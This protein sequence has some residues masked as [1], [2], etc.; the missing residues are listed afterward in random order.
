MT[1]HEIYSSDHTRS[2]A[3]VYDISWLVSL[4]LAAQYVAEEATRLQTLQIYA[5]QRQVQ[6]AERLDKELKRLR[7]I[8]ATEV[9]S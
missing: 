8:L 2:D 3:P 9:L 6:S 5:P 4:Q 1:I 7:D